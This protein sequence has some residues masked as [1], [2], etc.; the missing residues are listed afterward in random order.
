MTDIPAPTDR[1]IPGLCGPIPRLVLGS[2]NLTDERPDAGFSVLDAFVE[3]GGRLVDTALVYTGGAAE[4]LIGL[5]LRARPVAA[6]EVLVLT[7]GAHPDEAWHSRLTPEAIATDIAASLG[8]LGME[9]VDAWLAHRDDEAVPVGEIVD[10]LDALVRTGQARTVGVSNWRLPRL[11]EAT[12]WAA[13][14]DRAPIVVSSSYLGLAAAVE[15]PWPGCQSARDDETLAWHAASGLP[16]LAWSSQASGFFAPAFD[17]ATA[18]PDVVST[19]LSE[20]NLARRARAT[21]LGARRGWDA[22]QVAL[23]WVLSEPSAPFAAFGVRDPAGIDRAW[24]ALETPLT[25]G[26][27]A[28]LDTGDGGATA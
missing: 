13:A 2:F 17:P 4:R 9:T 24:V 21:E 20:A 19:Y 18:N 12:A 26:E 5:W 27:R 10:A 3:R 6:R 11:R 15:V 16:L 28:W 14:N 25:P 7:K 8:R 23:A 1:A 22:A